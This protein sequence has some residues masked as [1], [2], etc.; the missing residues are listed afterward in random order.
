MH[1]INSNKKSSQY[2]PETANSKLKIL[3]DTKLNFPEPDFVDVFK[4]S[5]DSVKENVFQPTMFYKKLKNLII[6]IKK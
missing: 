3:K 4:P 1:I 2:I 5:I 6:N